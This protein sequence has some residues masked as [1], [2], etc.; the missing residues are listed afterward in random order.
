MEISA[1]PYVSMI[2]G[3]FGVSLAALVA[4]MISD[5]LNQ[6]KKNR[7]RGN[8]SSAPRVQGAS[9]SQHPVAA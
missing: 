9:P 4:L 3:I 2:L 6:Q 5:Q 1:L 8:T 7:P